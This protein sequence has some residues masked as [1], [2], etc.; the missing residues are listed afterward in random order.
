MAM[1]WAINFFSEDKTIE[2]LA[3][4]FGL[5]AGLFVIWSFGKFS[6]HFS[7]D[8]YNNNVIVA[9]KRIKRQMAKHAISS[10]TDLYLLSTRLALMGMGILVACTGILITSISLATRSEVRLKERFSEQKIFTDLESYKGVIAGFEGLSS[11]LLMI[12]LLFILFMFR[13]T[14]RNVQRL[15]KRWRR[16]GRIL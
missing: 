14:V 11:A 2:A 15:R 4:F 1:N 3:N 16:R 8:V 5:V 7:I 9:W 10:A 6:W 13:N 12:G